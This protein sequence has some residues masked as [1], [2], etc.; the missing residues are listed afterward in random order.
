MNVLFKIVSVMSVES[1][2]DEAE[3]GRDANAQAP[4]SLLAALQTRNLAP[5]IDEEGWC[6]KEPSDFQSRT[7]AEHNRLASSLQGLSSAHGR[8][9]SSTSSMAVSI[10]TY[11]T[12]DFGGSA[13][14]AYT[15][16]NYAPSLVSS[17]TARSSST[18]QSGI[19]SELFRTYGLEEGED[20]V[21]EV[22][23]ARDGRLACCFSFLACHDRFNDLAQWDTHCMWHLR[24]HLPH[25]VHCPFLQCD[26]SKSAD[27][28][29]EAWQQRSIHIVGKHQGVGTVDTSSRPDASLIHHLWRHGIIDSA[30]QKELRLRGR[31]TED[32]RAFTRSA[33]PTRDHRRE[34]RPR[35]DP[36]S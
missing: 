14:S 28:G 17:S 36:R 25:T 11:N 29:Q 10:H 9:T 23:A 24:G 2:D 19:P 31:L 18:A 8:T 34:R 7:V 4:A 32:Q 1:S 33:G 20:G 30:E 22:P 12:L 26:W 15:S 21:P 27:S 16:S 5:L 13:P 35:A 6:D 3:L